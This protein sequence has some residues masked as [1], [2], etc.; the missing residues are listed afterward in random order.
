M[1]EI[2]G[3]PILEYNVRL[4]A[5]YGVR[6]LIINLH[7]RPEAI[8]QHFGNGSSYGVN[9]SYSS[10][11]TLLGTAGAVGRVSEQLN[12]TFLVLY[13][14]NLTDCN[15]QRLVAFHREKSALVSMALF[16]RQNATASG[17]A[18]TDGNDRIIRF[19]EKPREN[20]VFSPWVNAGMLVL[21]PSV[22]SFIPPDKPCDF[23]REILPA[24]IAAGGLVCGYRM[25]E[26]LWWIDSPADLERTR[27][28][29][30]TGS[31]FD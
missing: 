27:R 20:E 10:E 29:A 12:E 4:C 18:E 24:V 28:A 21:E 5:Q 31:L 7:H 13:G 19:L 8:V 14:D 17:I 15:L 1:I 9:I 26:R 22:L 11:Q 25:T 3:R 23:G 16:Y 30:E 6:N 2:G